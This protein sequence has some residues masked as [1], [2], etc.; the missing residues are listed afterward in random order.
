MPIL[1]IELPED[2]ITRLADRARECRVPTVEE[3]AEALLLS[4]ASEVSEAE[5][6]AILLERRRGPWV[7]C[8]REDFERIRR[9]FLENLG[10][11]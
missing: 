8:T 9:K 6:E 5:F 7:D 10:Q 4:A 1:K 3:Y 11:S 2:I